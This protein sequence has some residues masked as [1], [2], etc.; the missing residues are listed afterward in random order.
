MQH[1]EVAIIGGG[2]AGL[3]A[4]R[5]L[6]AAGVDVRLYEARIRPG[7]RI[8]TVDETG[9][10]A[11]NGF[12]LGPS[13]FWPQTQPAMAALVRELGLAAF[14]QADDGDRMFERMAG[15]PPG[16]Y[17]GQ[18]QD[19]V[20]MRLV[21]GTGALVR[22][23]V[24]DLPPGRLHLGAA[25]SHLALDGARVVLSL[26]GQAVSANHVIAALPPRLL[27]QT[28]RLS[29]APPTAIL[30]R[31]RGTPTWMAPHA[32]VLAVYDRPFWRAAGL[33]GSAQ[34]LAGPMPEI[35]DAGTADGRAA[36]FG[37]V[38]IG[39]QGRARL[40]QAALTA[41]CIAQLVRLFGPEAGTPRATLVKDWAC[42][43]LTATAA[44]QAP[45]GHPEPAAQPLQGPWE[46]A[47]T[48]A[49]S[50]ASPVEPGYLAG[51]VE[52]SVRAVQ[53]VLARR[54]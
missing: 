5:L 19:P 33:S 20:S 54:A 25:V 2:L 22:R 47:L 11:E 42:D 51:A 6:H 13:W 48:L 23:I 40:G 27:A 43:P 53:A 21:G 24:R 34:S 39:A 15:L 4:A 1:S 9:A 7:G 49:G 18:R 35:H 32:K 8:L 50:E 45:S 17:P 44:D 16:R 38:G 37:F 31:W 52:A 12:D 36:L 29:P 28:I 10:P 30:A 26:P 46:A 3:N 14:A 41:A